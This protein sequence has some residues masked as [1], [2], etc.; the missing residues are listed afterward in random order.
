LT[1]A[2]AKPDD[3]AGVTGADMRAVLLVLFLASAWPAEASAQLLAREWAQCRDHDPE[4]LIRGCSAIIHS[5]KETPENLARAFF[6]RGR[7]W[8]DQGKYD[9][10]VEDFNRALELDPNYPDAFN[11]RALAYA[12]EQQ[13]DHALQDF[14]QAIKLDPNYAIA[15]FNRGLTLQ[16]MGHA[17]EAA[18]DLARAKTVGP[19]LT[20]PKE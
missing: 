4:R 19:R 20:E 5:G 16:S 14:N 2:H 18:K 6:D 9:R 15:I 3:W 13:Y 17:D 1:R 10:A 7:A 12:G 8:A 11:G